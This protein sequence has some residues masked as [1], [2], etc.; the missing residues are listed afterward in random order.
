MQFSVPSICEVQAETSENEHKI[1]IVQKIDSNGGLK[2]AVKG[3]WSLNVKL[4]D[5][6]IGSDQ[7]K[8]YKQ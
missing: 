6:L 4:R 2:Y 3:G 5:E 8:W 1:E 7:F